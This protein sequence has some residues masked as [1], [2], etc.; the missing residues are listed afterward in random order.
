MTLDELK[1]KYQPALQAMQDDGV[2]LSHVH[3]AGG[4]LFVQGVAPSQ[5]VKNDV[6]NKI[7][8]IDA[9]YGDLTCDLS[10]EADPPQDLTVDD[11][12]EQ[13]DAPAVAAAAAGGTATDVTIR[14]YVVKPGDSLSK[15]ARQFYGDA[16]EYNQIF[17]ANRDQLSRPDRIDVGQVLVIP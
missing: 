2:V 5:D 7:K 13:E 8:A 9:N 11:N 12:S 16:N 3:L 4:K 17:E 10:V 1:N 15:I 6:W 14:T